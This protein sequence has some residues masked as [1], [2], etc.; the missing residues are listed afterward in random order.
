MLEKAKDMLFLAQKIKDTND[1]NSLNMIIEFC[2]FYTRPELRKKIYKSSFWQQQR[3]LLLKESCETCGSKKILVLQH[4]YHP[5]TIAY[6]FGKLVKNESGD[7]EFFEKK[8]F[9]ANACPK[10]RN[11]SFHFVKKINAYKC[12]YKKC[13]FV[14]EKPIPR[15][16]MSNC[17]N[18]EFYDLALKG[19]YHF[20]GYSACLN[21]FTNYLKEIIEYLECIHTKT[22]CRKCAAREDSAFI[23][24]ANNLVH[25]GAI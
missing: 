22:L 11:R 5:H 9:V 25:R 4:T 10:C 7:Y 18:Y 20:A 17:F 12:Y 23:E 6:R 1:Y 15:I 13:G 2:D 16:Y 14:F 8:V 24:F 3:H 21:A 19:N